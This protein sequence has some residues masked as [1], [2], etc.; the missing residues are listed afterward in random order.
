[1]MGAALVFFFHAPVGVAPSRRT[2]RPLFCTIK[3]AVAARPLLP[4]VGAIRLAIVATWNAVVV[5]GSRFS[6]DAKA[7]Q[8][9]AIF[10]IIVPLQQR[11]IIIPLF[12]SRFVNNKNLSSLLL[13]WIFF[14]GSKC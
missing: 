8:R 10:T 5:P 1:M 6:M 13:G 3:R 4:A 14:S 2:S 7:H 9:A 12:F 11:G